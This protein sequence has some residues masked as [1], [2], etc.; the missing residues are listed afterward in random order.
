MTRRIVLTSFLVAAVGV[1]VWACA[2]FDAIDG[3]KVPPIGSAAAPASCED[4]CQRLAALCGYAPVAC[5]ETCAS[6]TDGWDDTHKVCAGE[7]ASCSDAL[8]CA[9]EE[10]DGDAGEEEGEEDGGD[11]AGDLDA[12]LEEDASDASDLADAPDGD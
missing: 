6:E 12:A 7:A 5:V 4:L 1:S 9:N 10:V 3:S 2:D 11:T 8:S